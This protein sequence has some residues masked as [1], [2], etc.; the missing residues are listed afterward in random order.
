[1]GGSLAAITHYLFIHSFI[2][3]FCYL[4]SCSPRASLPPPR[5]LLTRAARAAG[6]P[7]APLAPL[8]PLHHHLHRRRR[9]RHFLSPPSSARP[10]PRCAFPS[11]RAA[12]RGHVRRTPPKRDVI[13]RNNVSTSEIVRLRSAPHLGSVKE[14]PR[15]CFYDGSPTTNPTL[16]SPCTGSQVELFPHNNHTAVGLPTWRPVPL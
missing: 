12:A 1:M 10:R 6:A 3:L 8:A 11:V 13:S 5:R 7:A 4:P 15:C 2:D 14:P 9:R 16:V